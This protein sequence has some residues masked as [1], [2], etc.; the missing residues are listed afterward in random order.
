MRASKKEKGK[1]ERFVRVWRNWNNLIRTGLTRGKGRSKL[2]ET[3]EA[4]KVGFPGSNGSL[5]GAEQFF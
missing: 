5:A 1:N 2:Y 4:G 3:K